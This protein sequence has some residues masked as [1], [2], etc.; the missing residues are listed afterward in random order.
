M[1]VRV[2]IEYD[3]DVDELDEEIVDIE[4][5]A[6][7][8]AKRMLEVDYICGDICDCMNYEIIY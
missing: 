6:K 2:S 1:T 4:E 8:K 5:F 7:E 3:I